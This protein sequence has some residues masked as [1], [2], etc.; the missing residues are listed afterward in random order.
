MG[1]QANV[2]YNVSPI[3]INILHHIRLLLPK[4]LDIN[5]YLT[6]YFAYQHTPPILPTHSIS[7][8]YFTCSLT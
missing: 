3:D 1:Y 8:T 6:V 4:Y 2:S 7:T 5:A